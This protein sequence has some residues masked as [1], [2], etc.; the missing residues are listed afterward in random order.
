MV[1]RSMLAVMEHLAVR[2][3][4][5]DLLQLE[6]VMVSHPRHPDTQELVVFTDII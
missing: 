5:T 6:K 4:V 3:V 1:G 2:G